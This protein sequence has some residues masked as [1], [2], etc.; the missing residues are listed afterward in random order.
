[1]SKICEHCGKG[2]SSGHNVSHSNRKTKRRFLPNLITKRIFDPK[3][4]AFQV[5]KLCS[6]CLKT[7]IKKIA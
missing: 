2:P 3:K 6:K 1:M 4:K 7:L 5:I